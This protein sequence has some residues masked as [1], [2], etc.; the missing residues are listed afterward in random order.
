[1]EKLRWTKKNSAPQKN[2]RDQQGS[3]WFSTQGIVAIL[4]ITVIGF[5][6]FTEHTAHFLG[7]LPFLIFLLCPLMHIFMHHGHGG[8]DEKDHKM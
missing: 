5:Y 3:W 2:N 7:I 8:H 4:F 1:M 6:L